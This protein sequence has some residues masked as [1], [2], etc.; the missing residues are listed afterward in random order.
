MLTNYHTHTNFC[1]GKNTVD[2]VISTAIQKGFTAIGFS[3]HGNTP[4]DDRYCIQ[5]TTGYINAV[6]SAKVKYKDKIQIYLGIEED[7]FA[8]VDRNKF[9]YII[10]SCH[11]I[12]KDG[13][14]YSIDGSYEH[15]KI[16]LK[17][18]DNDV[19]NYAE[20]YYSSFC[21]YILKRKPDIIGHF[22]LI[23]KFDEVETAYFSNDKRYVD[24]A[25]KYL[26]LA[27]K[28]NAIFEV[29]TGAISRGYKK[30]PYPAE[31][32]LH[33]LKNEGAKIMLSSDCHDANN[34]E[35]FFEQTRDILKR[36]GFN[37]TVVLLDGKFTDISL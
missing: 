32:L 10:G 15:F 26:R 2:E 23:T 29:N 3:G 28:S 30:A 22:D 20:R 34:L 6:N 8:L 19:I 37:K 9:D 35:F 11:Y 25:E 31:N 33:I 7:A 27:L 21:D 4:Y 13:V 5:D 12:I 1:D 24:L 18:F 14:Y 17:A 36:I 16:S